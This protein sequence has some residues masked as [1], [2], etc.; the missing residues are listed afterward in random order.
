[1]EALLSNPLIIEVEEGRYRQSERR[2]RIARRR[3]QEVEQAEDIRQEDEDRERADDV[4]VL[5]AVVA[6]DVVQKVLEAADGDL[7][8]VL[9]RTRVV[10]T[11]PARCQRKQDRGD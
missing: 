1:P 10:A 6:D 2:V 8:D 11:E 9:E 7:Q 3:L 4:E 5:I